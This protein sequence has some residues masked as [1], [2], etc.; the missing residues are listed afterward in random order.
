[1]LGHR[2]LSID[3]YLGILRRRL[4]IIL[5]PAI[6]V[7]VG[8]YLVSLKLPNEY[9]SQ[10]LVLVEQQK[11][12]DAFVKPVVSEDL[13]QRL[14]TMQEQ[15]LSR[16]RLQPI[17]ERFGLFK[18]QVGKAPMED[19]VANLRKDITIAPIKALPGT[20]ATDLPGFTIAFTAPSPRLAQQVCEE[21]TS[22][23]IQENLKAREQ[24]SLGTTEFLSN[25]LAEAKRK[26]DDQDAKLAV[27]KRK[28]I[29][30]L[31][32]QEQTNLGLL[33]G[34]NTQ[35]EAVTQSLSRAQADKTYSESVLAQQ[36]S[37]LQT[38][39]QPTA[40]PQPDALQIQLMTLQN[41]LV[42]AQ[43]RY[44]EDH[45]DVIKLK[46]SIAEVKKEIETAANAPVEKPAPEGGDQRVRETPQIQQLRATIH[47]LEQTIQAKAR[48]Q[49]RLQQQISLVQSR[50]SLSPTVEQE[51]KELTRDYQTALAFYNDLLAKESQSQM[52]TNLE[53]RQQGEQFRVMDPPNLPESPSFP[54]RP[55]FAG[56]GLGLGL[57][58]G[59]GIALLLEMRD[60]S[61][62]S[63]SDIK[64]FLQIPTLAVIPVVGSGNGSKGHFWKRLR[65][66]QGAPPVHA[67]A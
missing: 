56:A 29:G 8:A 18:D 47:S 42:A 30:A 14:S 6:I 65:R 55:L 43:A 26:L 61:I 23:F 46:N 66:K 12:P 19:L 67:E 50:L 31:P 21:I 34:L 32:G 17:I 3:D 20:R 24:R 22:M 27:F 64:F 7:P 40:G 28:Y 62:R 57:A 51:F 33:T 41:Q 49:A 5:I 45:P 44:T 4:W 16:T 60:K 63:E 53:R 36:L 37:A 58:L 13:F 59:I 9:T 39:Q 15:I 25:Q 52:A 54:N 1:M 11:V 10:T 38:V 2:E 48:D 35:L